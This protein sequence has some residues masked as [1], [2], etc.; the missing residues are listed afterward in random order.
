MAPDIAEH[1]KNPARFIGAAL[2]LGEREQPVAAELE[3]ELAEAPRPVFS[4]PSEAREELWALLALPRRDLGLRW[5]DKHGLLAELIPCWDGNASR[6]TFRLDAVEQVHREVWREGLDDDVFKAICDTH[7]VVVDRRL[8]RW[9]LTAL[10]TMLAGGDIEDPRNWASF[11][12][13]DLHQLGATEAEIVWVTGI[14]HN[15]NPAILYL[16]GEDV[17]LDLRPELVVAGLS[18]L[19][20][21]EPDRLALAV[22]RANRALADA[23]NPLDRIPEDDD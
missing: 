5:L 18:T 16:R 8:N 14:I 15:I 3:R 10:A 6:R 9:A 1:V 13:R 12:R 7:D 19:S 23:V 2:R 20:L 22:E 17:K 11:V 4:D 21:S